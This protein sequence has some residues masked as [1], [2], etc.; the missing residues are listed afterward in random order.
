LY[1]R[2]Q[3]RMGATSGAGTVSLTVFIP[4]FI[5]VRVAQFFVFCVMFCRSLFVLFSFDHSVAWPYSIYGL[6][7][8]LWYLQTLLIKRNLNKDGQQFHLYQQNE[9]PPQ[10]IEQLKKRQHMEFEIQVVVSDRHK[11]VAGFNQLHVFSF[12]IVLFNI[13]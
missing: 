5:G 8:L 10:T 2:V 1:F 12:F 3:R 7:L 6:W 4:V 9:Q 13:K 11:Y